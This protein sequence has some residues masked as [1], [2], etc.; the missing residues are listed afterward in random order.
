MKPQVVSYELNKL[1]ESDAIVTTDS[2]TNTSWAARYLIWA[3][4]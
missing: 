4:T 2:G 3:R 1:L